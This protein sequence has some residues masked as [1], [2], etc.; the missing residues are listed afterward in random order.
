M[1]E[2]VR[3]SLPWI[4]VALIVA[5]YVAALVT[6]SV[7]PLTRDESDPLQMLWVAHGSFG[8][9]GLLIAS[10]PPDNGLG[11]IFL[12]VGIGALKSPQADLREG[13]W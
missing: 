3:R 7:A 11:W 10:L 6:A 1:G 5:V 8:V 2:R 12:W 9:V 13:Q 4:V